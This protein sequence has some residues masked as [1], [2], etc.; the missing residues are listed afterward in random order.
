MT[1]VTSSAGAEAAPAASSA[2]RR[3]A[4][5]L[6]VSRGVSQALVFATAILFART[7]TVEDY[8]RF[9]F[10]QAIAS[11]AIIAL[12][13]GAQFG[14]VQRLSRGGADAVAE[15]GASWSAR[16][17]LA[18]ALLPAWAAFAWWDRQDPLR[19][20]VVA[21]GLAGAVF[22]AA[23]LLGFT[24]QRST[25]GIVREARWTALAALARLVVVLGALALRMPFV[26][27]LAAVAAAKLLMG[28]LSLAD[29]RRAIAFEPR[30]RRT[31]IAQ[32][33]RASGPFF[34]FSLCGVTY[35]QAGTI[36][37][38]L[39]SGNR[40]A[41]FFQTAYMLFLGALL[42]PDALT[43]AHYPRLSALY[44]HDRAGY[45]AG[46]RRLVLE[47]LAI[48]VPL[49]AGFALLGPWVLSRLLP[50]AYA[51]SGRILLLLAVA[52]LARCLS[53]AY[54]V[55]LQAGDGQR[56]R[57]RNNVVVLAVLAVCGAGATARWGASGMAGA[58]AGAE[59]LL[60]LLEWS[61]SRPLRRT[62][63]EVTA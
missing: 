42:L 22:D 46:F 30:P 51:S 49:A 19:P 18:L 61:A 62:G 26:P 40:D 34:V 45:R 31:G 6:T 1:V 3:D 48:G 16:L 44:A 25:G 53:Y 36:V 63:T 17:A 58:F 8:G 37:V 50:D 57:A 15:V 56:L 24:I 55:G 2:T 60:L 12:D 21:I 7:F 13:H 28:G 23:Q 27:T 43:T 38:S 5:A 35:F 39:W 32:H 10:A 47:S 20:L 41:A 9:A 59:M 14:L 33:L 52:L 54:G 11:I 29:A 4:A